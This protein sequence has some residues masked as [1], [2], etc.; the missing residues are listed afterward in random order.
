MKKGPY[1]LLKHKYT[2]KE[3]NKIREA[4]YSKMIYNDMGMYTN[5]HRKTMWMIFADAFGEDIITGKLK[6]KK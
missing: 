5:L 4:Y 2:E 6:Y 1:V 3:L